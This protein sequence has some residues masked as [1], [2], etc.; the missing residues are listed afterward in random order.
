MYAPTYRDGE[1]NPVNLQIDLEQIYEHFKHDYVL[2]LRLHPAV[3]SKFRNKYPDFIYN[4]SNYFSI[5]HLLLG[6]DILITDYSSIPFEFSLLNKPMIFYTYDLE[7]YR[8][9]R[10][11][12]GNF[13]EIVPGPIVNT[14]EELIEEIKQNEFDTEKIKQFSNEWNEYCHGNSSEKLI[15]AI[16]KSNKTH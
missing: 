13:T 3:N 11:L 2:F 4:V 15:E 14:T 1:F 9:E 7:T 6:T 8:N 10:G 12:W 16:Y 5:N